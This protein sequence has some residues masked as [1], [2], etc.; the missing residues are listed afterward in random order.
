MTLYVRAK[1]C[2]EFGN[3]GAVS[4]VSAEDLP[5]SDSSTFPE[6]SIQ[7]AQ[8]LGTSFLVLFAIVWGYK[9]IARFLS[10]I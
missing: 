5:A 6:L 1:D 9:V 7:D 3:C 4:W 10:T 8:S 2:D